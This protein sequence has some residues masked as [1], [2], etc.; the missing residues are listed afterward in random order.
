[1]RTVLTVLHLN[2]DEK[3]K[4]VKLKRDKKLQNAAKNLLSLMC[5]GIVLLIS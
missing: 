3:K 5:T 2:S 4:K 1:M